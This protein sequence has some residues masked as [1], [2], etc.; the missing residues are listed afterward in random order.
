MVYGGNVNYYHVYSR[1]VRRAFLCG[2]DELT[3]RDYEHRRSW[4]EDRVR[5]LSALFSIDLCSYAIM[6]NHYHLVVKLNPDEPATW[7]DDEVLNRWTALFKG[8]PLL[9]QYRAGESLTA[10]E[11]DAVRTM[12]AVYRQRLGCLSWFMKSLN[13]P[14]ARMANKEDNCTGHFWEARFESQ[15]L[16]SEHALLGAMVYVDLN[17]IRAKIARTPE[18]SEYTSIKDRKSVV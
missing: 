4:V 14:I 12:T 8:P 6:S 3:G 2:V 11:R 17:P 1:C 18:E 9:Q 5:I 7:S 15:P 10:V 13:E 16:C